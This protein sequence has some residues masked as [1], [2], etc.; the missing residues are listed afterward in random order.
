[1]LILR[2]EVFKRASAQAS[3][4]APVVIT[5][6]IIKMCFP[7]KAIVSVNKNFVSKFLNLSKRDFKVC[8]FVVDCRIKISSTKGMF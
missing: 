6:S 5:S 4:V 8:V 7:L 1:M 3:N 2:S